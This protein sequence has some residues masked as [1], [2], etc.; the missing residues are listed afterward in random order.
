MAQV[1][2]HAD[3]LQDHVVAIV[4]PDPEKFSGQSPLALSRRDDFL[5]PR[6]TALVTKV[7]GTP[8]VAS[9][10]P[11]LLAASL[12][13]RVNAAVSQE[14]AGYGDRAKLNGFEKIKA[15]YISLEPFTMENDLLTP[16]FK[17]KR[18]VSSFRRSF[19]LCSTFRGRR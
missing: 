15:I 12:D 1:Y 10:I 5:I 14:L 19:D 8:V 16:T 18:S 2:V 4:V 13:P 7:T 6:R 11:A 9:N 17:T 3:S